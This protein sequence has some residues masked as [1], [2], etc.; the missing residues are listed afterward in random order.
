MFVVLTCFALHIL[1]E[2]DKLLLQVITCL[3]VYLLCFVC[4][5]VHVM[6][7]VMSGK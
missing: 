5:C 1:Y 6:C 4:V 7:A 3:S 2:S